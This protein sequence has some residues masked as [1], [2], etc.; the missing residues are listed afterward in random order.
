MKAAAAASA[1]NLLKNFLL[2]RGGNSSNLK[3]IS[4]YQL[5]LFKVKKFDIEN[6]EMIKKM[7]FS[8]KV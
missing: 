8:C 2:K 7:K 1:R 5:A 6:N 4:N 3:C